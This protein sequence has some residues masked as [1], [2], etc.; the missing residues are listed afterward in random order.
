MSTAL[1]LINIALSVYSFLV[2][3]HVLMSWVGF[4]RGTAVEDFVNTAVE[5]VL[6]PIRK[7]LEPLQGG[8]GID[9]SPMV[10]IGIIWLLRSLVT[11]M[12]I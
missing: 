2:L 11:S 3:I 10:L 12:L 5:P 4:G 1:E 6:G 9:F 8:A 7:L